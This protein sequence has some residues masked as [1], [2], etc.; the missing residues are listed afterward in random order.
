MHVIVYSPETGEEYL[1]RELAPDEI[2]NERTFADEI[3]DAYG[4]EIADPDGWIPNCSGDIRV[5]FRPD[6]ANPVHIWSG[7]SFYFKREDE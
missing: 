4:V 1:S 2:M 6:P 7:E 5:E 3:A